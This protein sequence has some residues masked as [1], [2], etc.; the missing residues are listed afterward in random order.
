MVG[1]VRSAVGALQVTAAADGTSLGVFADIRSG[2]PGSADE[3]EGGDAAAAIVVGNGTDDQPVLAELLHS[4]HT[5]IE[6]LDRWRTPGADTS[7][8]WEERFGESVYLPAA[9]GLL[10]EIVGSLPA[11]G[12]R[13][14]AVVGTHARAVKAVARDVSEHAKLLE[15]LAVEFGNCGAAQPG[16]ALADWLDQAQA[17]DI[18]ILVVI[19][20]GVSAMVYRA[21]SAVEDERRHRSDLSR[22]QHAPTDSVDYLTY[23]SWRGLL[24]SAPARRPDPEPP[25]APPSFRRTRW[26][27]ALEASR[28]TECETRQV[29]PSRVCRSCHV[30]DHMAPDPLSGE[31]ARVFSYT[32]DRLAHT[33]SPPLVGAVIDFEGGG[34]LKCEITD[35]DPDLVEVGLPVEMTFR[36]LTT[37]R[38]VHNYFW[39]ARPVRAAALTEGVER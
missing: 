10:A 13:L 24:Q 7:R 16:L 2:A 26:K 23:L 33:P 35:V 32:I 31:R 19:S 20:D 34:R 36:R 21:T 39:K 22:R 1:S 6:V 8:S 37:A 18:F 28:C 15:D 9:R 11:D 3:I 38:G 25:L 29:P 30:V 27:F 12:R 14:A 4:A 17:G 5:T